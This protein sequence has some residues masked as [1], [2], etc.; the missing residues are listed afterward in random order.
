MMWPSAGG[1]VV[2]DDGLVAADVLIDGEQIGALTAPGTGG[3][4]R[5]ILDARGCLVMPGAIDAHAHVHIPYVRPDG[6]TPYSHDD[7][8]SASRAAAA[9]GTTTFIDFAMQEEGQEPLDA[10]TMRKA[11]ISDAA[12]DVALHCWLVDAR[13]EFLTQLPAVVAKG[14][15]SFKAFMAY[16][17]SGEAMDDGAL[18]ARWSNWGYTGKRRSADQTLPPRYAGRCAEVGRRSPPPAPARATDRSR[19]PG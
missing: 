8:R 5:T 18:G 4:A 19:R 16:S 1:T 14:I 11:A 6:S 13:P 9:G 10:V 3:S 12:V 7:F 17:Q 2:L 15:P